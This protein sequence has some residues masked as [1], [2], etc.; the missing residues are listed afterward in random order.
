MPMMPVTNAMGEIFLE[1]GKKPAIF[2]DYVIKIIG[3]V[4]FIIFIETIVLLLEL[5]EKKG[6]WL[7]LSV[8]FRE[9]ETILQISFPFP[10]S[11]L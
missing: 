4:V 1:R 11:K 6:P 8:T 9:T 3:G 10:E 5:F 2:F 7:R